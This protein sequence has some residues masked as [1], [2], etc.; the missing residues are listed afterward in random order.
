MKAKIVRSQTD[1]A[2]LTFI[3]IGVASNKVHVH[4]QQMKESDASKYSIFLY[5]RGCLRHLPGPNY[6]CLNLSITLTV[7]NSENTAGISF[8]KMK[9]FALSSRSRTGRHTG[10][11]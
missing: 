3:G 1:K 4:L 6:F 10:S 8:L 9:I 2:L 11:H 5:E 7:L